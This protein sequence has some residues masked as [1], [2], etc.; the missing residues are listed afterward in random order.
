LL[1]VGDHPY[2]PDEVAA[3]LDVD[4][5]GVIAWDPRTA[6]VLTGLHGAVRDLRRSPL[7]RSAAT[8]AAA[9]APTPDPDPEVDA[10]MGATRAGR[11]SMVRES[12][13]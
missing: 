6:A 13:S 10:D 4:V 2:G 11:V 8:L 3:T 5:A 7:V 1:L 9:L 12:R